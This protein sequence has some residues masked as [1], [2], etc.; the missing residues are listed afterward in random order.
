MKLITLF[1]TALIGATTIQAQV[2]QKIDQRETHDEKSHV[3]GLF[4]GN[5]RVMEELRDRFMLAVD[6][7]VVNCE[8]IRGKM[9]SLANSPSNDN[10]EAWEM[11][12]D[13]NYDASEK[14]PMLT[15][16]FTQI[17]HLLESRLD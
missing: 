4:A 15:L 10:V 3:F 6:Q 17:E 2:R 14:K 9:D 5:T 11:E 13:K 16:V 8:E 7:A 1:F 12:L